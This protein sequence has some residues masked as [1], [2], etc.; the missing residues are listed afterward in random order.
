MSRINN[1]VG[2]SKVKSTDPSTQEVA[3]ALSLV[4]DSFFFEL[5]AGKYAESGMTV[6]RTD[7]R[8]GPVT[9]FVILD[10]KVYEHSTLLELYRIARAWGKDH[11]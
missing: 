5:I 9:Y 7:P 2:S 10:G 11:V 6:R 4:S 3:L 8:D 1:T